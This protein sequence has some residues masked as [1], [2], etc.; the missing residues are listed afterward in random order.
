MNNS[1]KKIK[2]ETVSSFLGKEIERNCVSI[3]FDVSIH[4]TGIV[5]IRTTN[6]YMIIDETLKIITPKKIPQTDAL[7]LFTEQLESFKN[8]I[9]Q[10]Y[11]IDMSVIEDCFFGSNVNT[12][13]ALARHSVLVY[14]RFKRISNEVEFLLPSPA[15]S[16]IGF[17]KSN[18]KVKGREL[19][20]EVIEYINN[21]LDLPLKAKDTDIA[22]ATVLALAGLIGE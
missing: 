20:K 22:D 4:S 1:V 8:K 19:K 14:D 21:A 16:R 6:D 10:K 13:K 17:K 15:R 18:K 12:L 3:G 11:K 7:D 9:S 2:I 5:V